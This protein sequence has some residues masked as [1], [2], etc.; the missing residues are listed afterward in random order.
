MLVKDLIEKLK[1]EPQDEKVV[2]FDYR[3]NVSSASGDGTPE[4]IY[5]DFD[6]VEVELVDIDMN[7]IK[8]SA[9]MFKNEQDYD[10]SCNKI[11]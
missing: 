7:K 11:E 5:S 6:F 2:L 10:E 3:M 8:V 4:G 9:L 1:K